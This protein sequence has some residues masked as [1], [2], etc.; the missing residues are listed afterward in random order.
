MPV[1]NL[2]SLEPGQAGRVETTWFLIVSG[3]LVT[4]ATLKF[5]AALGLGADP[6]AGT[7]KV[8]GVNFRVWS[9]AAAAAE[10]AVVV[11]IA[12]STRPALAFAAIR[13]AF[14]AIL[15]Y[16]ALLHLQGGGYCGCL[17]NLLA[18]TPLQ[19]KEGLLL[20]S[21]AA[22]FFLG[23]EALWAIRRRREAMTAPPLSASRDNPEIASA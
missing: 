23:N 20:G 18:S 14:G 6:I 4:T 7:E 3:L 19:E 16:R 13:A 1:M 2:S 21:V 5:W 15:G 10:L 17:G 9:F 12:A 22:A 11:L 8:F